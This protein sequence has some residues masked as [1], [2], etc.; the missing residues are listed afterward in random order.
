[1]KNTLFNL[2]TLTLVFT[3]ALY[4][5]ASCQIAGNSSDLSTWLP[6][7]KNEK[8]GE[9]P[10]TGGN[11]VK[12]VWPR[13]M[14]PQNV[15][16]EDIKGDNML[17]WDAQETKSSYEIEL[18]Y[19]NEENVNVEKS[20]KTSKNHFKIPDS[21]SRSGKNVKVRIRKIC[22]SQQ[23]SIFHS[24]WV[25]L[26]SVVPCNLFASINGP[27]TLCPNS[28]NLVAGPRNPNYSYLWNTS[29]TTDSISVSTAGTYSVT[30]SSS[31]TCFST[32]TKVINNPSNLVIQEDSIII[33]NT[34]SR[35]ISASIIPSYY[36]EGVT[37]QIAPVGTQ[38]W[39]NVQNGFPTGI[40][41]SGSNSLNLAI[42]T[43]SNSINGTYKYRISADIYCNEDFTYLRQDSIVITFQDCDCSANITPYQVDCPETSFSLTASEGSSYTWNIG[44]TSRQITLDPPSETTTYIVTVTCDNGGTNTAT[45]VVN[46]DGCNGEPYAT[47]DQIRCKSG[48]TKYQVFGT[49]YI[50]EPNGEE[51]VIHDYEGNIIITVQT[52]SY[53][54]EYAFLIDDITPDNQVHYVYFSGGGFFD[55]EK[56]YFAPAQC[57]NISC[58]IHNVI[59][60]PGECI[61]P[62]NE[63]NLE[64]SFLVSDPVHGEFVTV[65]ISGYTD[66]K[67]IMLRNGITSYS[68]LFE[69]LSA[70]GEEHQVSITAVNCN[71]SSGTYL[72]PEACSELPSSECGD[73]Y[74]LPTIT[75][76]ELLQNIVPGRIVTVAGIPFKVTNITGNGG[77]YSGEGQLSTPFSDVP[78]KVKFSSIRINTDYEVIGG[79]VEGVRFP[80]APN[81]NI[82]IGTINFG[83]DICVVDPP[84]EGQD[85]DGFNN[86]NGLN[87]RGFGR[88]SLYYPDST[89]HDPNGYDFNGLHRDTGTPYDNFGCDMNGLDVN[90][91]I[92]VRDSVI[93]AF[94]DQQVPLLDGKIDTS[95]NDI[96]D[97][98]ELK[99]T[100]LNCDS[101]RNVMMQLIRN[102]S[103]DSTYIVGPNKEYLNEGMSS[104]FTEEPKP[105][106]D[107]SSRDEHMIELEQDHINIYKCDAFKQKYGDIIEKLNQADREKI[108]NFVKNK[109]KTLSRDQVDIFKN[110]EEKFAEWIMAMILEYFESGASYGS[111]Y[112]KHQSYDYSYLQPP[113]YTH[114]QVKGY[115]PLTNIASVYEMDFYENKNLSREDKLW[116][117]E[118]GFREID[119]VSRGLY[120]EELYN[121]MLG[122]GG[123]GGGTTETLLPI[124]LVKSKDA[125]NYT[126]Y[127]DNITIDT[128][129]ARLDAYFVYQD[130]NSDKKFVMEAQGLSW[131]LGGLLG[132]TK[133]NLKS[134]VE[135]RLSNSALLRLLPSPAQGP[136]GC[137]VT[138]DCTGF[139][140]MGID[141][142]IE[143]CR[144]M[145][146]PLD[147]A[148][149]EVIPDE[150]YSIQINMVLDSW[151]DFYFEINGSDSIRPFTTPGNPEMK[152]VVSHIAVDMSDARSPQNVLMFDGYQSP[153][154]FN[155]NFVK[156]WRGFYMGEL[157]VSLPSSFSTSNNPVVVGVEDVIID[158]MGV[159]GSIFAENILPIEDGS[160]GGWP[161]SIEEV[162]ITVLHNN[163]LAGGMAGKIKVPVFEDPMIY[164]ATVSANKYIFTVALGDTL[165]KMNALLA[166]VTLYPESRI[167]VGYVD[168]EF[169]AVA[170]LTGKMTIAGTDSV[171]VN[172]P[173]VSFNDFRV[174]NQ[175]P[176]FDAGTWHVKNNI[177][178]TLYGF[179]IDLR[180]IRPFSPASNELGVSFD[181]N[182]TLPKE[183]SAGGGFEIIGKLTQDSRGRQK[184][185]YDRINLNSLSIDVTF[186]AG[187]IKGSLRSFNGHAQYGKGF[188]GRVKMFFN[189]IGGIDCMALFGNTG[190]QNPIKYFFVDASVDLVKGIPA[191]PLDING[192]VG[193]VAYR[194]N[195]QPTENYNGSNFQGLPPIGQSISGST[196]TPDSTKGLFL[197][198]GVKISLSSNKTAFNG[199]ISFEI[200][201]NSNSAGGGL[202]H[203]AWDGKGQL[204]AEEPISGPLKSDENTQPVSPNAALSAHIRIIY[205]FNEQVLSGKIVAF[206]KV[207]NYM[208]GAMPNNKMVD[209]EIHF[210]SKEWY[211]NIGK[212]TQRCGINMNLLNIATIQVR[213]YMN[214]GSVIPDLPDLPANV[215]SIASKVKKLSPSGIKGGGFLF[216]A[217]F[218][219]AARLNLYL[220]S[221]DL[222]AG[223]GFD[224][225][226]KNYGEN[227]TCAGENETLGINGWY[228][229]GQVYA[230]LE[231]NVKVMGANVLKAGIAAVLQAQLPNPF[232]A[233]ATVA[234]TVKVMGIK[235]KKDLKVELGE[236][237]AIQTGDELS[238]VQQALGMKVFNNLTPNDGS[239]D[240]ETEIQ[241]S[242]MCNVPFNEKIETGEQSYE[243][244]L[245]EVKIKS[246]KN[247]YT[248]QHSVEFN[249]TKDEI[250]L[251]MQQIFA[252]RDIIQILVIA[253]VYRNGQHFVFDTIS[254]IF[255]AGNALEGIPAINVETSYPLDGMHN[256]MK[257]EYNRSQ[258]FV[259]LVS[260][261]PEL[262]YNIPEGLDQV[263]KLT[264]SGSEPVFFDY[265]YDGLNGRITFPMDPAMLENEKIYKIEIVRLPK[266]SFTKTTP[267]KGV[268]IHTQANSITM[269]GSMGYPSDYTNSNSTNSGTTLKET[270]LFSIVFRV[271]KFNTFSSKLSNKS[272]SNQTTTL[273]EGFDHLDEDVFIECV[274]QDE[275]WIN[276]TVDRIL[277]V[278][279][280]HLIRF[281]GE[282][283][284]FRSIQEMPINMQYSSEQID[285]MMTKYGIINSIPESKT[286]HESDFKNGSVQYS[287]ADLT[288]RV[289]FQFIQE[290]ENVH[291]AIKNQINIILI[292]MAY[293][294]GDYLSFDYPLDEYYN[295][296]FLQPQKIMNLKYSIPSVGITSTHSL[297]Y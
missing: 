72:A 98:L 88:D 244:K 195:V 248:Y 258:G 271:S 216:G 274:F 110:E 277:A 169:I 40:N 146:L 217:S 288:G 52:N 16:I 6:L 285:L 147:T 198:A 224:V 13:C 54:T 63:Y 272:S 227:A 225:I 114:D 19:E 197:R 71:F 251:K 161:F 267:A 8:S 297:Q 48:T 284:A 55:Y 76:T 50:E 187:H 257:N 124:A 141:A 127:L 77:V 154:Y 7:L 39:Q 133:L 111:L 32:A 162:R 164:A 95:V 209:A 170:T 292:Q 97:D 24:D 23:G 237:C 171:S 176:Y 130:Q 238:P 268:D 120:L 96:I 89:K 178:A 5:N 172:F 192:F 118:Q 108:K 9:R 173:E 79:K 138:W 239:A 106:L 87:D 256:F 115:N 245:K 132:E 84:Q 296:D 219:I 27:I 158:D 42:T 92:C 214:T 75:N 269:G 149:M 213:T 113:F 283:N 212:P 206:L 134:E 281:N 276:T 270:F 46:M 218:E 261:M 165:H 246:L 125:N 240:M 282:G 167:T 286:L 56:Y 68:T 136:G 180:N 26:A 34:S 67:T 129:G 1:M 174:S 28:A 230:Y 83:G 109:L 242:V 275:N 265:K 200:L 74:T 59:A 35:T 69:G 148:T 168:D 86:V 33:C 259:Q 207:G 85:E 145:I 254:S 143:L 128:S 189:S 49:L 30:V 122:N 78:L 25:V 287:T 137:F 131:G 263:M 208:N 38:N 183:L 65:S 220:A 81:Y 107:N 235:I 18:F 221:G 14:E 80:A 53:D 150:R 155:G 123:S 184:W 290:L 51:V 119:G 11:P 36:H 2:A 116:L 10:K 20:F 249:E 204:M 231:G 193:G 45:A 253:Q 226:L 262:F 194:M 73:P 241:P 182:V 175:A 247:N 232:F 104:L 222:K 264:K 211:I 266:G 91:Q 3:L 294:Q 188:Q 229:M 291:N 12:D 90:G 112:K 205:N 177:S 41:Y 163:F 100:N 260:G 186:S 166:D 103:Y 190:G 121:S 160:L 29:N 144:D 94:I 295:N 43:T 223:C 273:L 156:E 250:N 15:K 279:N 233:Q 57:L 21:Y 236:F 135:I 60:L 280:G 181:L 228:A 44:A 252:A 142:E 64:V 31:S 234:V 255:T 58:N 4:Y 101:I 70:D 66:T 82:P 102:N 37:W 278:T 191:P 17:T 179:K 61:Q 157:S 153:H 93:K 293:E 215:R 117:F 201:F 105:L 47:F 203:I 202:A 151:S 196:Y 210:S 139:Q 289:S 152:W 159:S 126:I 22:I 199:V 140:S 243:V 62:D 99:I 185:I